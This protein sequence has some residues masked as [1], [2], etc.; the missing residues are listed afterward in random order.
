MLEQAA[1][2]LYK[3]WFVH[4]RF[5]GHEHVK[6]KDGVPEGWGKGS[7]ISECAKYI[8]EQSR[9]TKARS[10]TLHIGCKPMPSQAPPVSLWGM[11]GS[12]RGRSSKFGFEAGD[13]LFGQI[14]RYFHKYQGSH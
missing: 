4:L 13:I 11:G 8:R 1:R 10:H 5:P 7:A 12:G 3:E 6:I 9:S 14:R 2:L